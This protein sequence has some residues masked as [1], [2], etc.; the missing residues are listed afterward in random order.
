MTRTAIVAGQFYE[1]DK[2]S[3]IQQIEECFMHQKGPGLPD[4]N[5]NKSKKIIGA[6]CPHAGYLFSGPCQAHSYKAIAGSTQSEL[7]LFIGL[8]HAGF[9]SSISQEDWETPLGII[10]NHK[11]FGNQLSKNTNIP[12]DE[13]PHMNE[14]SIEVQIPFLQFIHKYNKHNQRDLKF[15]ALI[16]SHDRDYKEVSKAIAETIKQSNKKICIIASSDFTHY[17][18]NYGYLPFTE[19]KKE[20]LHK[21]DNSAIAH[22]LNIDPYGF[23]EYANEKKATICGKLAIA[24]LLETCKLLGANKTELLSYYSSGDLTNDYDN[25]VGYASIIVEK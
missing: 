9:N 1:S 14:H 22:I 2:E 3:L 18:V 21:L 20:N 19:N 8:S 25:S 16:I 15:S 5:N 24:T 23:L 6:I 13:V 17:G 11:E 4:K 12:I 7:Y 10:K